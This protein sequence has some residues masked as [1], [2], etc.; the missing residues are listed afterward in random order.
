M[1]GQKCDKV[2]HGDSDGRDDDDLSNHYHAYG[3]HESGCGFLH[4]LFI[5]H[6]G[7]HIHV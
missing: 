5:L 2:H 4:Y 3:L 1:L 6:L 7:Y